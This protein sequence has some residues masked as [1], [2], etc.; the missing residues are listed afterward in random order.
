MEITLEVGA[1]IAAVLSEHGKGCRTRPD[2]RLPFGTS[3]HG[4]VGTLQRIG[5]EVVV[6]RVHVG[7]SIAIGVHSDAS[8]LDGT[9][10]NRGQQVIIGIEPDQTPLSL[11]FEVIGAGI[12]VDGG[13]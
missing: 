4:Y 12:G 2:S 11:H 10:I 1:L 8:C 9:V 13:V 3:A 6:A 7:Q 5:H